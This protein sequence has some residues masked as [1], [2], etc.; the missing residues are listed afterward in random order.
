[1]RG[2]NAWEIINKIQ[3]WRKC[4]AGG[5]TKLSTLLLCVFL[6]VLHC[7]H[8]CVQKGVSSLDGSQPRNMYEAVCGFRGEVPGARLFWFK[9]KQG[10]CHTPA[11]DPG[12]QESLGARSSLQM[13]ALSIPQHSRC[14]GI[15]RAECET[16]LSPPQPI[17]ALLGKP[18]QPSRANSLLL[19][20]L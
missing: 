10:R 4:P 11:G 13:D 1:M 3:Q 20:N 17:L 16:F 15:R 18:H 2:G 7:L 8:V 14:F 12:C 9:A 5:H 6:N 19:L